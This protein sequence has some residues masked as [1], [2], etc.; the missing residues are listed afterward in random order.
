[1][2]LSALCAINSGRVVLASA[3]PRRQELLQRVGVRFDVVVSEF[4]EDL[5]KKQFLGD[6]AQYP[7]CTARAKAL[8]VLSKLKVA[9]ASA[10]PSPSDIA[11]LPLPHVIISADTIVLPLGG[12]A[13][14]IMEKASTPEDCAAMLRLLQG[15]Q[16]T[17]ITGVVILFPLQPALLSGAAG[18]VLPVR[19]VE[20]V[21]STSV[22][23]APLDDAAIALYA[24]QH[25]EAWRGKAGAYG[26]Q[27]LAATFIPRIDGDYYNVMGFPVCSVCKA[28]RAA[29]D[30][31]T[32]G[33][34]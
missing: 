19:A 31:K 2:L 3:S 7:L 29:V 6:P 11:A 27:D 12:T 24:Q 20:F 8:D 13:A 14:E 5:D 33:G 1:M 10:S 15:R 34:L 28:L 30:D 32:I 21:A 9:A 16:H 25:P 18:G 26:I 17:V 23:F 22:F 4:A